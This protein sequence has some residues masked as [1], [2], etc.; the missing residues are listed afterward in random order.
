[1][2]GASAERGPEE[3]AHHGA[4]PYRRAVAPTFATSTLRPRRCQVLRRALVR[5]AE[6]RHARRAAA[7]AGRQ[8]AAAA[9]AAG[10]DGVPALRR[11]LRQ[12]R[13]SRPRASSAP[14]RSSTRTRSTGTPTSVACRRCTASRSTS[15]CSARP[16]RGGRASARSSANREPLPMCRV[17]VEP[18]YASRSDSMGCVNPEFHE[19]PAGRPAFRVFA[20][21]TAELG[22]ARFCGRARRDVARRS[23]CRTLTPCPQRPRRPAPRRPPTKPRTSL[24]RRRPETRPRRGTSGVRPRCPQRP[25]RFRRFGAWRRW[26][27]RSFADLLGVGAVPS[28][29][30][31]SRIAGSPWSRRLPRKTPSRSPSSPRRCWRAGRGSSRAARPRR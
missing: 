3:P 24:L 12:G 9:A 20:T 17:E 8:P 30:G 6:S 5:P 10:R 23:T 16:R 26:R 29:P 19:L 7:P 11:P 1:M 31:T 22:S 21:L 2:S 13:L 28:G 15:T 4:Q 18:C 14:V 25:R 27:S